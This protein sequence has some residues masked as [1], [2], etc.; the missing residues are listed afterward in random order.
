MSSATSLYIGDHGGD[1]SMRYV[2][3]LKHRT[4]SLSYP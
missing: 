4:I 2:T 3:S 1:H